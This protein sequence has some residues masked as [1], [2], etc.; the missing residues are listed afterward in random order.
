MQDEKVTSPGLNYY[1]ERDAAQA[2]HQ[3]QPATTV[4]NNAAMERG[5]GCNGKS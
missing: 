1:R 2:V 5:E 3:G 4:K